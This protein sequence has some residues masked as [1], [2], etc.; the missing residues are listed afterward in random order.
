MCLDFWFQC[1]VKESP[2]ECKLFI[3]RRYTSALSIFRLCIS[4]FIFTQERPCLLRSSHFWVL[5][6]RIPQ[7]KSATCLSQIYIISGVC[8]WPPP[9]GRRSRVNFR[10]AKSATTT[11]C[12]AWSQITSFSVHDPFIVRL[13]ATLLKFCTVGCCWY[14]MY[15]KKKSAISNLKVTICVRSSQHE[16]KKTWQ[17]WVL[18][19][20][21]SSFS[22][23][24]VITIKSVWK[25]HTH[26]ISFCRL[27]A[28]QGC[29]KD[30]NGNDWLWPQNPRGLTSSRISSW[31]AM[32]SLGHKFPM[33]WTVGPEAIGKTQ[34]SIGANFKVI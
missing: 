2:F 13:S 1:T 23:R 15:A 10:P 11:C 14:T 22:R 19:A 5:R 34:N 32:T 26:H 7:L 29:S 17:D 31:M 30:L 6:R 12:I 18:S 33:K 27:Q 25:Y 3:K 4:S 9:H 24:S 20:C 16:L 8:T 21:H 28:G